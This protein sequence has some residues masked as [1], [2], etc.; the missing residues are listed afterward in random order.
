M[1]YGKSNFSQGWV[2]SPST[3][4]AFSVEAMF[5]DSLPRQ[6]ERSSSISGGEGREALFQDLVDQYESCSRPNWDGQGAL[7]VSQETYCCAYRFVEALPPGVKLPTVGAEPD[8]HLT[9]EWYRNPSRVLSV[10][11]GPEGD[12]HYAALLGSSGKSAGTL[13][14]LGDV[15][16]ELLAKIRRIAA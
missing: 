14:F 13:A 6:D 10:S 4:V 7:P 5:I 15:P 16:Q 8:G 1:T 12:L 9:L 3:T 11:I 2:Y